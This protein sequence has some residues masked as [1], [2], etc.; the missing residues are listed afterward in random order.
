LEKDAQSNGSRDVHNK[1]SR[2]GNGKGSRDGN[3]KGNRDVKRG[4]R[5][6]LLATALLAWFMAPAR[7]S[8]R[9]ENATLHIIS[10][11]AVHG[12]ISDCGCKTDQK[13]G[14]DLR[15]GLVDSLLDAGVPLLHLDAGSFFSNQEHGAEEVSRF[16]WDAMQKMEVD[17]TTPGTRE[18]TDWPLFRELLGQDVISV[19]STNLTHVENGEEKPIGQ[20]YLVF[21]RGGLEIGV[22]GLMGGLQFTALQIPQGSDIRF[23]DP[24]MAARKAVG[25]LEGEVDLIVLLSQLPLADTK[26]ILGQIPEIDVAILGNLPPYNEVPERVGEA[27]VQA[28]GSRGQYLGELVLTIDPQGKIV[29]HVANNP[30]MWDP[31]PRDQEMAGR[32]ERMKE[33]VEEI[34]KSAARGAARSGE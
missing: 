32:V 23:S 34:R 25:A 15:A 33:R 5:A 14:L 31:L 4:A 10:F 11:G 26:A 9:S 27:F 22:L 12:E 29:E 13:G 7:A 8:E 17:A 21:G 1:G 19:V 6:L 24:L 3:S 18:L 30:M 20:P 28:T 2:Y 16:L